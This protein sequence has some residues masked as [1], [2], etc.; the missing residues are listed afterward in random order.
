[1]TKNGYTIVASGIDENGEV[2]S[3]YILGKGDVEILNADSIV[4]AGIKVNTVKIFE[5]QPEEPKDGDMWYDGDKY[6]LYYNGQA[7]EICNG[8][9]PTTEQLAAMNSGITA[10]KVANYTNVYNKVPAQTFENDNMLA[11]KAFVN[12]S[13]QTATANFRGN[14]ETFEAI[15]TDAN[16]YPE[17]YAGNKIPTTNDYLVV[18][19]Y[20]LTENTEI[21]REDNDSIVATVID[22]NPETLTLTIEYQ[23]E[24]KSATAENFVDL[25]EIIIPLNTH[26]TL[27]ATCDAQKDITKLSSW[28]FGTSGVSGDYTC[29]LV[30]GAGG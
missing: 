21:R 17:D 13:V 30:E 2:V 26:E 11:D 24:Q 29:Y 9:E 22:F 8:F 10:S 28:S 20:T 12:S 1:M 14:W 27:M 19:N 16:L 25:Y 3:D 5:E 18:E 23:G 15:P 4:E 7:T 6:V